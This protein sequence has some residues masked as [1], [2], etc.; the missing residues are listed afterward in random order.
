MK[1]KLYF[2]QRIFCSSLTLGLN[3]PK[4]RN[5]TLRNAYSLQ[6]DKTNTRCN[7]KRQTERQKDT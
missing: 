6:N 3:V 2:K 4:N 1:L 5:V 7:T